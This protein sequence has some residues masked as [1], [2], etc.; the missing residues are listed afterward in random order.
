MEKDHT[1][2]DFDPNDFIIRISPI[3]EN[4]EW[5]GEINVGQITTGENTLQDNDYAHLSILTDMLICA[6]PLIE[7]DDA[8]RKELFKLVEEQFGKDKPRV[9]NRDGNVLKV[10]F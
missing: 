10:N 2:I 7:K 5:S 8:I 1:F 9:I 3:M 6:I 4:G